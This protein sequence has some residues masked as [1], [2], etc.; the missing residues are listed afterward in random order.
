[1]PSR[2]ADIWT[3]LGEA[4]GPR[5]YILVGVITGVGA[6]YE[7]LRLWLRESGL[8]FLPPGMGFVLGLLAALS[9]CAIAF[10]QYAIKLRAS[11]QPKLSL[12]AGVGPLFEFESGE[13]NKVRNYRFSVRNDGAVMLSQCKAQLVGVVYDG[14][15][16]WQFTPFSL[17][18][19]DKL[20][21]VFSLS[22]G[23]EKYI[24]VFRVPIFGEHAWFPKWNTKKDDCPHA[25]IGPAE[26]RVQ[27][28]CDA[29]PPAVMNLRFEAAGERWAIKQVA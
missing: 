10:L 26:F 28:L 17:S 2:V 11:L 29:G 16:A 20:P 18:H 13:Q 14:K 15:S 1:M 9:V 3:V 23:E 8:D 24:D 25:H 6:A 7:T 21:E 19:G 22:P 4:I 5:R 27:V 12:A